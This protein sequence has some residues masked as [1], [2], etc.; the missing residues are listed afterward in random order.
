MKLRS[1]RPSLHS[2]LASARLAARLRP[3]RT[4]SSAARAGGS[5]VAARVGARKRPTSA[6]APATR[7]TCLASSARS[8]GISR[9]C[10][11]RR[12]TRVRT[13]GCS[14]ASRASANCPPAADLRSCEGEAGDEGNG[15]LLC[16]AS[17][18]TW[19]HW[20]HHEGATQGTFICERCTRG[21]LPDA[22]TA[23]E[24]EAVA[25]VVGNGDGSSPAADAADAEPLAAATPAPAE[26]APVP[27]DA[28]PAK[29]LVDDADPDTEATPTQMIPTGSV[30]AGEPVA[31]V[32]AAP[33]PAAEDAA[34]AVP[35]PLPPVA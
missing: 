22:T 30:S 32:A 11:R 15:L 16:C 31:T 34:P 17:C 28:T 21:D 19:S 5:R 14:S 9:S 33:G 26:P 10:G 27:A 7:A 8:C 20:A 12:S 23:L 29:A 35:P 1:P 25:D 3:S 4:R 2:S 13:S 6:W 18:G 24:S